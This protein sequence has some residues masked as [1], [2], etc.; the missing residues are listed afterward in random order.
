MT[1][2]YKYVLDYDSRNILLGSKFDE[3][4]V[5]ANPSVTLTRDARCNTRV[6]VFA[7]DFGHAV[8]QADKAMGT[9]TMGSVV[10]KDQEKSMGFLERQVQARAMC[11]EI[12]TDSALL[13]DTSII[14]VQVGLFRFLVDALDIAGNQPGPTA[15][16]GDL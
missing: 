6:I 1:R 11:A 9:S 7:P 8:K 2:N 3:S 5:S 15:T 13:S 4:S 14:K 12:L 16:Y 10:D